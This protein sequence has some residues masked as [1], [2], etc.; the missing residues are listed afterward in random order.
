MVRVPLECHSLLACADAKGMV[1]D[2]EVTRFGSF[3]QVRGEHAE[4]PMEASRRR[5]WDKLSET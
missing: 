3:S 1:W 4:G 2:R 5:V